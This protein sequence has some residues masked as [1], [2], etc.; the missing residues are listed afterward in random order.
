MPA[1][2]FYSIKLE[3][4]DYARVI[5]GVEAQFKNFFPGNPMDYFYLDQFF[6]R[7]YARD[8]RF[9]QVFTI[10]TVIAIF[11]ASMGLIGL[12]SFMAS[13][14]TR[15]IGIRTVMGSTVTNI[16]LLLSRGFMQPVFLAIVI[17]C[18]LSWYLMDQWLQSFPYH[19]TVQVWPFVISGL[20]VSLVAFGSVLSQTLKA[21]MT[22]PAET[23]KYE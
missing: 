21:A 16:I 23:L 15:E 7:Q 12:A 5:A 1:S 20:L 2:T 13:Q 3:T 19:T 11:I 22:K 6:N 14:R 8:D 17:A 18:P 4:E 9:G 10:F